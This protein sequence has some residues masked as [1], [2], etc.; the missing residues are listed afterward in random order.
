[1]KSPLLSYILLGFYKIELPV[2][3]VWVVIWLSRII[4]V[5]MSE[6]F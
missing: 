4:V 5:Q 2:A 1:M 6:N 3:R